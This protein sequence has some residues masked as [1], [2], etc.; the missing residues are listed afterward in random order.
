[1]GALQGKQKIATMWNGTAVECDFNEA[2]DIN[3]NAIAVE[4]LRCGGAHKPTH[5]DFGDEQIPLS[6]VKN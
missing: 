5:Y 6:D 1:M 3:M 4:L 2:S